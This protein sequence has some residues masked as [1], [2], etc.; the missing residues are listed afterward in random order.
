RNSFRDIFR[1]LFEGGKADLVLDNEKD[2]LDS[3]LEIVAQPPGKKLQHINLL[4][5]GERAMTTI[6]FI[7][8]LFKVQPSPFY[9]LDEIDAPLDGVNISRFVHLLKSRS[10]EAQFIII[11]HNKQTIAEADVL[12]GI[13]MEESGVSKVVSV[14][15]SPEK[16]EA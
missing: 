14:K 5:G 9:L 7:F 13:T 2:I 6:A 16:T 1:Q 8:A 11:T 3:G 15:F 10:G 12:Y 4:S